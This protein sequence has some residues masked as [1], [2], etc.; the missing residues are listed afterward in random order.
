MTYFI[1]KLAIAV[2]Q[3]FIL[4]PLSVG[5]S[6]GIIRV[7]I[8]SLFLVSALFTLS[9]KEGTIHRARTDKN[10]V[11]PSLMLSVLL[12]IAY[13]YLISSIIGLLCQYPFK[14]ILSDLFPLLEFVLSAYIVFKSTKT[15]TQA[16]SLVS[17][18]LNIIFC[19]SLICIITYIC[20]PLFYFHQ[21][22]IAGVAVK[23]IVDFT[24]PIGLLLA[25]SKLSINQNRKYN[26]LYLFMIFVFAICIFLS[27]L[28]NVWITLIIVYAITSNIGKNRKDNKKVIN[29]EKDLNKMIFLMIGS[30]LAICI[31]NYLIS[32][33]IPDANTATLFFGLLSTLFDSDTGSFE[34]ADYFPFAFREWSESPLIGK[35]LGAGFLAEIGETAL[36]EDFTSTERWRADIPS[37]PAL[38]LWKLGIVGLIPWIYFIVNIVKYCL[39]LSAFDS[40]PLSM[41]NWKLFSIALLRIYIFMII[42]CSFAFTPFIHYPLTFYMGILTGVILKIE[43]LIQSNLLLEAQQT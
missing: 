9:F 7:V 3:F 6:G 32:L 42:V 21:T 30:I 23:R 37:Y 36:A 2:Q 39:K 5:W 19:F 4:Y 24:T 18:L 13:I 15:V 28:K 8:S 12:F 10:S 25:F 27:F 11:Q 38:I 40:F 35:S 1:I 26:A 20:N 31:L 33:V 14:A 29:M 16:D 22:L 34:R 41:N 17:F 43:Y